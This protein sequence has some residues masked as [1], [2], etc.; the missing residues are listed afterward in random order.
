MG[1]K[2]TVWKKM[3]RNLLCSGFGDVWLQV[4][5]PDFILF[6]VTP[7]YIQNDTISHSRLIWVCTRPR[8]RPPTHRGSSTIR[9]RHGPV[10]TGLWK[11]QSC[12]ASWGA[13]DCGPCP[14]VWH[15]RPGAEMPWEARTQQRKVMFYTGRGGKPRFLF[16][17]GASQAPWFWYRMQSQRALIKPGANMTE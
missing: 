9:R 6:P 3:D 4:L 13:Q 16:H 14:Q 10:S 11:V 7:V 12:I 2:L 5:V 17:M 15:I 8:A 1:E